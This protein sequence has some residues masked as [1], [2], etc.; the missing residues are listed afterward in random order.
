[1]EKA[2]LYTRIT[3][4]IIAELEAGTRPWLKPWNAEHAA[5]RITRPLRHNGIP[6]R[7]INVVTL[8][9]TATARGYACPIWLTYKQAQELGAQV[10]KGEHGELVVYAEPDHPHRDQRERRG[11]RARNPFLEGIHRVQR[12][13]DRQPAAALHGTGSADPR[14][15]CRASRTPRASLPRPEPTSGTAET[16]PISPAASTAC[17]CRRS[18][19]SATL[20]RIT[21]PSPMNAPTGQNT[22]RASIA[23]SDASA[24]EMKATP[25]RSWSPNSEALFFAP[26]SG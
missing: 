20:N 19:P 21:R 10:R 11:D 15:G 6:Y 5:G 9:M 26:T 17:R 12:R 14:P 23:I 1:M 25:P 18:R 8:W 22:R 13:A 7:G 4:R 2:D 3:N 16:K 24:G